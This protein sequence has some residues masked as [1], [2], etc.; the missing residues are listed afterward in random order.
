MKIEEKRNDRIFFLF[1]FLGVYSI[2]RESFF[3]Q[4]SKKKQEKFVETTTM[5]MTSVARRGPRIVVEARSGQT[6]PSSR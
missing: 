2:C 5:T 4:V 3:L 1:F 6:A